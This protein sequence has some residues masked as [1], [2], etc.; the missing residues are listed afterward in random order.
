MKE[1]YYYKCYYATCQTE[2]WGC[3]RQVMIKLSFYFTMED[4]N[5]LFS[6][7]KNDWIT[8]DKKDETQV[9][10]GLENILLQNLLFC[11]L[12]SV[13]Y[14]NRVYI[15]VIIIIF[16]FM[17]KISGDSNYGKVSQRNQVYSEGLHENI[18][19][20]ILKNICESKNLNHGQKT[21]PPKPI[22]KRF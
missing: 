11:K 19:E 13:Q 12:Q 6:W 22:E 15:L 16:F 5:Q 2:T 14:L 17:Q 8:C 4:T 21:L 20:I 9:G 3:Y 10:L 1:D 7:S 18:K